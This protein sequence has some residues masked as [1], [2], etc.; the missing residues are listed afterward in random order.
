[1]DCAPSSRWGS[2]GQQGLCGNVLLR[3][4]IR[5]HYVTDCVGWLLCRTGTF[6]RDCVM[7]IKRWLWSV[8][9][10]CGC[11]LLTGCSRDLG[12]FTV[13]S[14]KNVNL[15]NFSNTEAEE[16]GVKTNGEDCVHM[17]CGCLTGTPNLKTAVDRALEPSNAY[18]LTN[19]RIKYAGWSCWF[20][21]QFR[22]TVEGTPVRRN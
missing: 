7:K 20:Y 9:L 10:L 14:S 12:S 8:S 5:C 16:S 6:L 4:Y 1:M 18:M 15:S 2:W 17:I 21:G 13:L 3:L 11:L 19:A 22:Y